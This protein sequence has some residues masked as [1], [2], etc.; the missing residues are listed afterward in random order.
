M[1]WG[2]SWRWRR[3]ETP[4]WSQ[5]WKFAQH[6][7]FEIPSISNYDGFESLNLKFWEMNMMNILRPCCPLLSRKH[8]YIHP[9]Y[10]FHNGIDWLYM[11]QLRSNVKLFLTILIY[12]NFK[13][14]AKFWFWKSMMDQLLF[15]IFVVEEKPM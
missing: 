1:L 7:W 9:Y 13:M 12:Q 14:L 6:A 3:N 8:E 11:M 15:C 4:C 2:A 5:K 10:G